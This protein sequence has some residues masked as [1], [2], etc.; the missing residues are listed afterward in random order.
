GFPSM[1]SSRCL[2]PPPLSNLRFQRVR[3]RSEPATMEILRS[4]LQIRLRARYRISAASHIRSVA[5]GSSLT[6][7]L[8]E[9]GYFHASNSPLNVGNAGQAE[10]NPMQ[11]YL[12]VL[13]RRAFL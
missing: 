12:I 11:P 9:N 13:L 5:D 3:A 8:T 6:Q 1:M 7:R 10:V 2:R 4:C